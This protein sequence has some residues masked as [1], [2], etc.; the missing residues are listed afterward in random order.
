MNIIKEKSPNK[1]EAYYSNL[2]TSTEFM[3]L[4]MLRSTLANSSY[5]TK[6][7]NVNES[8][9]YGKRLSNLNS[10]NKAIVDKDREMS[11]NQATYI[12]LKDTLQNLQNKISKAQRILSSPYKK[13]IKSNHN[14]EL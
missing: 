5:T 14:L 1:E 13:P 2:R 9:Y 3:N 4:M 6:L 7:R 11:K 12:K 10:I 8:C